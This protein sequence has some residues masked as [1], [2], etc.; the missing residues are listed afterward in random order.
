V[1]A[2]AP[3]GVPPKSRGS[4]RRIAFVLGIT[5]F[6]AGIPTP[7]YAVYQA[8]FG[9]GSG[10]LGLVFA[11]YTVGVVAMMFLV[12]P[13][14]DVVGR[15]PVL[16]LGMAF[17]ILS[18]VAFLLV[19]SV[20]LL[21]LARV[22]SGLAV[23]ATT[24]TATAAMARLEPNLDQHHVARV[25]VA[26]NF[27][28][29]ATGVLVSGF[30]VAYVPYPTTL[31]FLVLIAV[32]LVGMV[33]V[34]FTPETVTVARR[35]SNFRPES[36]HIPSSVW[37]P[38]W[39]SALAL[40]SCYSIYGFFGALAPTFVR[41][42]LGL[43]GSVPTAVVVATMF[44][45]AALAQLATAQVRDR[46]ALL[47][48][49]PLLVVALFVFA[50]AI[51]SAS[52]PIL[53]VAA[54]LLGVS[55]GCAFMGSVTLIDRVAPDRFRGEIL[56]AFYITGYLAL[57][58]PTVGVAFASERVGLGTAAAAFGII[59]GLFA[60]VGLVATVRTPTPPGGEGRP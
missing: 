28:G 42:N 20:A 27:G 50:L 54:A 21:A 36:V 29:V 13:M 41:V 55:V 4:F 56:S 19:S 8:R 16:H 5:A 10:V 2:I 51:L 12:G 46:R 17:T 14:S 6:G 26:A 38:F 47:L 11:A 48:G 39:I 60:V 35:V 1:T 40:A 44:G 30:L 18:G 22:A 52:F 23:G 25:S 31:V 59:L 57:A 58:I 15:K 34:T 7:L 3:P 45:S 33:A 43:G 9:F 49:F 37:T 53:E 32:S 24:S